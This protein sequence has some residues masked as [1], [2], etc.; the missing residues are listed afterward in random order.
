MERFT[1]SQRAFC[2]K[3]YYRNDGSCI[4][5]RRLFRSEYG[6]QDLNQCPSASVIKSW[7]KNFESTGSTFDQ[8]PAGR[9]TPIRKEETINRSSKTS[10]QRN[11][12]RSSHKRSAELAVPRT[13]LRRIKTKDL[14]IVN[15]LFI[16]FL[17]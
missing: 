5:V 11:P 2:V 9:P 15:S 6:L 7:V 8:K 16:C 14:S 3:N 10:V 1:G 13:S 12:G 17:V 4:V